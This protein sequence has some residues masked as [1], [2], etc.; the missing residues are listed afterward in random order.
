MPERWVLQNT[1]E[2]EVNLRYVAASWKAVKFELNF[3]GW[4][5]STAAV[6]KPCLDPPTHAQMAEGKKTVCGLFLL[7]QSGWA[8]THVP[9]SGTGL[10]YCFLGNDSTWDGR[11]GHYLGLNPREIFLS[12]YTSIIRCSPG[13]TTPLA[14]TTVQSH[15]LSGQFPTPRTCLHPRTLQ[16]N[17]AFSSGHFPR[18]TTK[19]LLVFLWLQ[20]IQSFRCPS[21]FY[22]SNSRPFCTI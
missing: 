2:G 18:T 14:V 7:L 4:V 16:H 8:F 10:L 5:G 3:E 21:S 15:S 12:R 13:S 1:E 20:D 17:L 19:V 6:M 9:H 22:L 11:I